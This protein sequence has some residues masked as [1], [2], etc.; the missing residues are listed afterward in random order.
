MDTELRALMKQKKEK[1]SVGSRIAYLSLLKSIAK[2]LNI[3][4]DIQYFESN[5]DTILKYVESQ[6]KV[7]KKVASLSALY[8]ICENKTYEN[9][10][11]AILMSKYH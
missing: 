2:H 5:T 11:I 8:H 9:A 7:F 6:D 4:D 10:Y 3:P 1:L